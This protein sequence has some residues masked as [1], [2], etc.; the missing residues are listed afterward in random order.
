MKYFRTMP[1]SLIT[2]HPN[3]GQEKNCSG[4]QFLDNPYFFPPDLNCLLLFPIDPCFFCLFFFFFFFVSEVEPETQLYFTWP[5]KKIKNRNKGYLNV[6]LLLIWAVLCEKR[7][8]E[9]MWTAKAQ[10]SLL[11]CASWSGLLLSAKKII[12]YYR[13]NEWR[14]NTWLIV[15]TCTGWSECA[16]CTCSKALFHLKWPIWST[17]LKYKSVSMITE[18]HHEQNE[19]YHNSR[20]DS[21]YQRKNY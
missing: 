12:G 4:F 1:L 18:P 11:I 9:H 7:T 13:M 19:F 17:K 6:H 3:S 5:Y 14:A 15:C 21:F 16:S 10:I 20:K 2:T 8:F